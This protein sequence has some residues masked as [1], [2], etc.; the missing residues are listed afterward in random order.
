VKL[1]NTFVIL[2]LFIVIFFSSQELFADTTNT[3]IMKDP[4]VFLKR[5]GEISRTITSIES[6]F[7][8]VKHLD[9]FAEDVKSRGKFYFKKDNYLRWEYLS[10][11]KYI[12]VMNNDKFFVKDEN[13]VTAFDIKSNK[14]IAEINEIMLACI[15]GNIL[16]NDSRFKVSYLE[17]SSS[18]LVR[19]LPLSEKMKE[20]L[21][22]IELNFSKSDFTVTELK[23]VENSGDYT[24]ISFQNRKLNISIPDEVFNLK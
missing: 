9:F 22:R 4:N 2:G 14:M 5:A 23:M 6:D 17:S 18:Y 20:Y 19:L 21:V 10:P 1:K 24:I 3:V 8:Q 11:L 16:N 15:R 13:K 12:L 7:K